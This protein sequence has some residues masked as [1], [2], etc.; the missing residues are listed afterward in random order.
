MHYMYPFH[1]R[2]LLGYRLVYWFLFLDEFQERVLLLSY[3][4]MESSIFSRLSRTA[5]KIVYFTD[6]DS[7][8]TASKLV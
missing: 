5:F 6:C 2:W 1:N 8:F 7:F 3:N 4:K